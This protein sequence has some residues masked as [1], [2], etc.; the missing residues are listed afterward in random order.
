MHTFWQDLRYATRMLGKNPAFSIVAV[1]TLAL[2]IGANSAIFSVV[3]AVL[4][5]PLPIPEPERVL[6][7]WDSAPKFDLLYF[8]VT[9]PNYFDW[10]EQNQVFEEM[11]AYREGGFNLTDNGK[12]MHAQ[13]ARVTAGFFSL[14]GVRPAQGRT[15]HAEEDLPGAQNRAVL[16][17]DDLW[18]SRYGADADLVGGTIEV[19]GEPHTVIGI[20]PANYPFPLEG[21]Q[22]W[23]P[24]T[25]KVNRRAPTFC[26]SWVGSSPGTAEPRRK[27]KWRSS[28][29][30]SRSS[31]RSPT[32]AT[33]SRC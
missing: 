28:P 17:S 30:A 9:V 31:V 16:L 21:T 10:R 2:G 3:H 14:L 26:A 4:L 22:L 5:R 19:D 27:P 13:G 33:P 18:R 25:G 11:A 23:V 32:R 8:S 15:F 29:P 6:R 20:M 1:L 7:L 12:P 24:S